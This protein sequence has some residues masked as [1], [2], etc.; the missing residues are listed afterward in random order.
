MRGFGAT[1]SN[2]TLVLINGRRINDLDLA[3]VDLST[4][5]AREHRPHR[6]HPRQQRRGAL[7]RRRGRRRDQHRAPRPARTCRRRRASPASLGLVQLRR[8]RG[9]GEHV[10]SG[11]WAVSAYGNAISSDGYRQ[12]NELQPAERRRRFPLHRRQ[13]GAYL[14][15][16]ADNQHLGFPGGRLVTPTFSLVDSDPTRR[17]DAV[18]LRQQAGPQRHR[19]RHADA[20]ARHTKLIVDGG[21]R[22]KNQ[23]GRILQRVRPGLRFLRQHLPDDVVADAAASAASTTSPARRAS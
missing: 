11:P 12:N 14:T 18:R 4:H 10:V 23:H 17:G 20:R 9:V 5:S 15:L 19:R 22:Q 13:G 1:A 8:R 21:I 3:G 7:R 6:D 16:S 2:N